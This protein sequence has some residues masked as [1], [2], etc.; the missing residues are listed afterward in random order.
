M[1]TIP[2]APLWRGG[3]AR[4]QLCLGTMMFGDQTGETE[5]GRILDAYLQ[6][7][8]DFID[9]ADVYAQGDSERILGRLLGD[10]R[11]QVFLATK[12]GN[13]M[14]AEPRSGTLSPGWI[15]DAAEA[16]A[17]RLRT[18]TIDLYY[19]HRDDETTPL[20]EVIGALGEL[21]ARGR[22]RHWGFS[23]FRAWKIAEMMRLADA[24]G[25][26]RPVMAQP[27]YHM[28]NRTAE[29]DLLPACRH[30]G[31]GVVPYSPLGRGVLTGKYRGGAVPKGSRAA[32]ADARI[33]ETEFLPETV[34]AANRAADHAEATG[35]DPAGLAIQWVL[36]NS[37]VSSVLIGPK[38]LAQLKGY[39]AATDV[40][41]RAEDE[42]TLSV[43]CA[44]GQTPTPGH[45][46]PRYPPR[47]RPTTFAD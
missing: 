42:R 17:E 29:T 30:F 35:R 32:R 31:V 44:S 46:D 4:A 15:L 13:T 21:I 23:N 22:I 11:G 10:R 19:L 39:L 1:T 43:L 41:Y 26:A 3:P 33:M 28:L 18:G 16:S 5:A 34:A 20:E 37:A 2:K 27:Y 45:S 14:K 7:G 38:T 6:A 36:A 8:G 9:T 24:L 40:A 25:V 12:V 47:G